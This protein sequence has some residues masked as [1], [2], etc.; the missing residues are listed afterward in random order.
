VNRALLNYRSLHSGGANF[1]MADGS[2]RFVS[3]R[4]PLDVLKALQTRAKGEVV[5]VD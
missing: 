1:T 5:G 2:V 4:T 3:D